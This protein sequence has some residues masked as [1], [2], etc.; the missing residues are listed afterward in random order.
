MLQPVSTLKAL[1]DETRLKIVGILDGNSLSVNEIM[2]A[3]NMGQSRIS[4]HLKIL[5]D[6]GILEFRRDGARVYY[7]ISGTSSNG[8]SG[9]KLLSLL[10]IF[11]IKNLPSENSELTSEKKAY[12]DTEELERL[13]SIIKERSLVTLKHFENARDDEEERQSI[14]ADPEFYGKKIC[15]LIPSGVNTAT[16]LGCG[17]GRLAG[18]L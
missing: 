15:S 14:W 17:S 18:M 2:Y 4:R 12:L 6:A 16:D 5:S 7:Q 10:E 3:L 1:A 11:G 9:Q 13:S 8:S